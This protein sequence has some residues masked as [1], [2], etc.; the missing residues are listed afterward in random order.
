MASTTRV[1]TQ[2]EVRRPSEAKFARMSAS[3]VRVD[4]PAES[5]A[6]AGD[7]VE[8]GAGA[9]LVEVDPH[10]LGRVEGADDRAV[11]DPGEP[12]V[13]LDLLLVPPHTNIRS[14]IVIR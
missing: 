2:I 3:P 9:N 8:R 6:A 5:V 4:R 10:R 14:H 13:V 1:E 7:V 11:A 12:H